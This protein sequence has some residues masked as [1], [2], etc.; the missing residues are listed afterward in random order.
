VDDRVLRVSP[1]EPGLADDPLILAAKLTLRVLGVSP[2]DVVVRLCSEIPVASGL[3]SGAAVSAA[4]ARAL[5]LAL[6]R[7]LDDADLNVLVFEVEK[8]SRDAEWADNTVVVC[9][10]SVYFV[11]ALSMRP[12]SLRCW[13]STGRRA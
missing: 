5:A 2:P 8:A 6:G 11:R 1:S 13:P 10:R 4:V 3:G 7:P 9:E 12:L